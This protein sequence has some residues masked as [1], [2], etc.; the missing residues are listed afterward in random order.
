[1]FNNFKLLIYCTVLIGRAV[2]VGGGSR[3]SVGGGTAVSV[4]G[5][6]GVSVD[7][8]MGVL[9]GAG[10]R[11][12]VDVRVGE[13]VSVRLGV[14]VNVAVS[15]RVRVGLD[16]MSGFFVAEEMEKG[17]TVNVVVTVLTWV[18]VKKA[19]SVGKGVRVKEDVGVEAILGVFV[20]VKNSRAK[21]STVRMRSVLVGVGLPRPVLGIIRLGSTNCGLV[22]R[23]M[24]NGRLK[25]RLHAPSTANITK[26]L[27]LNF[28]FNAGLLSQCFITIKDIKAWEL[29]SYRWE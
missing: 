18:I 19:V 21:A 9:V 3:V 15:V 24:I 28:P 14:I 8:G 23:E 7:V 2:S 12:G 17:V 25:A 29:K 13:G 5:G 27:L 1:M 4:G 20:G 26:K 11:E 6:S 16:A 10:V 22:M